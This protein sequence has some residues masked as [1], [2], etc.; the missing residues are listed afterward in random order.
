[1]DRNAAKK[2]I[3][4]NARPIDLAVYQYFLLEHVLVVSMNMRVVC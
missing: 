3:I 2:F 1:M 4:Q